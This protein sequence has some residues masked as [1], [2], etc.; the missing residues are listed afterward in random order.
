MTE[1]AARDIGV[2]DST[3]SKEG[4]RRIHLKRAPQP[5]EATMLVRTAEAE[6]YRATVAGVTVVM[7]KPGGGDSV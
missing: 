2:E 4:V 1:I 3:L 5:H 6:G 7:V